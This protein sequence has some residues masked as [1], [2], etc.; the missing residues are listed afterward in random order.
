MTFSLTTTLPPI[1]TLLPI[2][3]QILF[4][5]TTIL[6]LA[7]SAFPGRGTVGAGLIL[8]VVGLTFLSPWPQETQMRYG[9]LNSWF[10]WLP[11]VIK[12]VC[13]GWSGDVEKVYFRVGA[14]VGGTRSSSGSRPKVQEDTLE[15]KKDSEDEKGEENPVDSVRDQQD[16]LHM[17][18]FSWPKLLWAAELFANP[19]GVGWNFRLKSTILHPSKYT[20]SKR[21]QFLVFQIL[22]FML[23]YLIVDAGTTYLG[24]YGDVT[25]E[26]EV[27]RKILATIVWGIVIRYNWEFV[28]LVASIF[29]VVLGI[30]GPENWPPLFGEL[31]DCS[32]V[33]RFWGVYWQGI[34][35]QSLL[36]LSKSLNHLLNIPNHTSLSYLT[37]L[38]TAF[39]ISGFFHALVLSNLTVNPPIPYL[40]IWVRNLT[41]F[42]I[43]VIPIVLENWIG[44]VVDALETR[45]EV[46][47]S[48][49]WRRVKMGVGV[50]WTT[51][52]LVGTACPYLDLYMRVG[53]GD[54]KVPVSVCMMMVERWKDVLRE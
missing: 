6:A 1:Q 25:G 13:S 21:S 38:I 48:A 2:L 15:K 20:N 50:C 18:P 45:F 19:R 4:P 47:R 31:G 5:F 29:A 52:W 11:V 44:G 37:H 35:K 22:K 41:F 26:S 24:F 54:W 43:Q 14:G 32:S 33:G 8:T 30:S 23:I 9:I 34:L 12:L 3:P 46:E 42:L 28:W 17:K 39:F 10:Y 51:A 53:M 40:E 36:T 27:G 16:A 49:T 7:A